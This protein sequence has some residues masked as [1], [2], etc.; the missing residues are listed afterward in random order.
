MELSCSSPLYRVELGGH[1]GAVALPSSPETKMVKPRGQPFT[2]ARLWLWRLKI[3]SSQYLCYRG[4]LW[5]NYCE[6][7]LELL[8][9]LHALSAINQN[10]WIEKRL[11]VKFYFCLSNEAQLLSRTK[12]LR[13]GGVNR[14]ESWTFGRW[15]HFV[16][17]F[18]ALLLYGSK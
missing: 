12:A 3:L 18:V 11:N 16:C 9:H 14:G 4:S 7:N 15:F 6:E 13:V 8:S 1:W 17:H 5:L 2:R 10:N